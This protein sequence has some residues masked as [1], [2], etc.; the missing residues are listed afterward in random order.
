[1]PDIESRMKIEYDGDHGEAVDR[2]RNREWHTVS[3]E[4]VPG[5][6]GESVPCL[7]MRRSWKREC[8]SMK[9]RR[10]GDF[11]STR[12]GEEM[13]GFVGGGS[14]MGSRM[15]RRWGEYVAGRLLDRAEAERGFAGKQRRDRRKPHGILTL[16]AE[17][18]DKLKLPA[19]GCAV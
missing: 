3:R 9:T 8:A 18:Y 12:S 19:A 14:D 6:C 17:R 13:C 16:P 5:L 10:N 11:L 7:K 4:R 2:I 15:G 1:M